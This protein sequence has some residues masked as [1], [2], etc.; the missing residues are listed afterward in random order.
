MGFYKVDKFQLDKLINNLISHSDITYKE[1]FIKVTFFSL[2]STLL[3]IQ[4]ICKC[5]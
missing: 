3:G 1:S 2:Y 4:I 5:N